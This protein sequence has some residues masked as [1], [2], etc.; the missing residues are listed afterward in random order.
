MT[1]WTFRDRLFRGAVLAVVGA[2]LGLIVILS[3]DIRRYCGP[4][5]ILPVALCGAFIGGVAGFFRNKV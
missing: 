4:S 1:E 5:Y 3:I 2:V